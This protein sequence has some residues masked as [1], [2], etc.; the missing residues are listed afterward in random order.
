MAD[1]CQNGVITTLQKL[2]ARPVE[3][4]ERELKTI[5]RKRKMILLLPALVTEFDGVAMPKII[6]ELK[7]VD[8]LD[9]IVLSLD[10]ADEK[11]F[12][13][14]RKIMS[15]LPVDVRVVWHD[16]PRMQALQDRKSVV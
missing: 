8:Y 9:K 3:E 6:E 2:K 5:A 7:E 11:Q 15:V 4:I 12:N 14:I 13:R 10:R 16:G 1:F